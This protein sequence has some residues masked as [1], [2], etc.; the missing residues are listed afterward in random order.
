[1]K[2]NQLTM[3]K[4]LLY[5]ALQ[6][7]TE[8]MIILS[9]ITAAVFAFFQWALETTFL[10]IS[11]MLIIQTVVLIMGDF[12]TGIAA[13]KKKPDYKGIEADKITYTILKFI[14]FF[15]WL[16][17]AFQVQHEYKNI[18]WFTYV[19][20]AISS[21]PI[22]LVNLREFVSIGINIEKIY[23]IKPYIFRL[24]DRIFNNLEKA[25]EK[26]ISDQ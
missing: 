18:E 17:I 13:S 5:K 15:M 6:Y 1:M 4:T 14:M 23:G 21:F 7:K 12:F 2:P 8:A 16:W 22:I 11:I 9:G 25:F 10:G 24:V 3:M 19:L 26:K 20:S